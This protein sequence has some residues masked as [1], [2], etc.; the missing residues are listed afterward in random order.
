MAW[1]GQV[2]MEGERGIGLN[3]LGHLR[4][5]LETGWD[6]INLYG[7]KWANKWEDMWED[8]REDKWED[9]LEEKWEDKRDQMR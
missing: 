3:D 8:K 4:K 1:D 2:L 5:N 7:K 9:K 6:E